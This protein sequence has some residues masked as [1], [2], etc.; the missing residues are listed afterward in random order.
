MAITNERIFGLAVPLSLADI[1]DRKDALLNI[2]LDDRDI[3]IIEGC[4]TA[5]FDTLDL[6]TL[7]GLDLP[8]WQTFDRYIADTLTYNSQLQAA[9]GVDFR[10]RGSLEVLG[11]LS[12]TAFRYSLLDTATSTPVL[13]WGDISTSRVSSWS[14]IDDTILYGADVKITGKL[15]VGS[16]KTRVIPNTRQF[17]AEVPTHKI[18]LRL[19]G[20]DQFLLVMKGIP[21]R[22]RG[23]FRD[24]SSTVNFNNSG[25]KASWRVYNSDGTGSIQDFPDIGNNSSSTLNYASPFSSEKFI[26]IYKNPVDITSLTLQNCSIQELPKSVLPNLSVFNFQN[27][28]L[29]EFP[30]LKKLIPTCS[31]L[32]IQNNPFFNGPD[33][34]ERYFSNK[35]ANK[36]PTTIQDLRIS[37]CF[38]G[39]FEQNTLRKFNALTNLSASRSSFN[40]AYFFANSFNPGGEVPCFYGV[41]GETS[42]IQTIDFNDNDF[43]TIVDGGQ[44]RVEPDT[45]TFFGGNNYTDGL[46]VDVPL[47][48]ISSATGS[49]TLEGTFVVNNGVVAEVTLTKNGTGYQV[50]DTLG[51]GTLGGTGSGFVLTVQDIFNVQSVEELTSLTSLNLNSNNNLFKEKF[52]VNSPNTLTSLSIGSTQ[53]EMPNVASYTSLNS[54][55]N[56]YGSNRGSFHVG[57]GGI[58]GRASVT[59]VELVDGGTGGYSSGIVAITDGDGTGLELNVT[60]FGGVVTDIS[61]ANAGK[62]Y[63]RD[64]TG[65]LTIPGGTGA[66]FNITKVAYPVDD[67]DS[68]KFANCSSL[69]SHNVYASDVRGYLPKYVGCTALASYSFEAT[70]SIVA[71][72]PG[73][74][75]IET[76]FNSGGIVTLGAYTVEDTSDGNSIVNGNPGYSQGI[77]TVQDTTNFAAS[78]ISPAV[79]EVNIASNGRPDNTNPYT[80]INP[81][82]GYTSSDRI[83]IEATEFNPPAAKNESNNLYI[84]ITEVTTGA[85]DVDGQSGNFDPSGSPYLLEDTGRGSFA[86]S[87]ASVSVTV[88]GAG[89]IDGYGLGSSGQDYQDD[90]FISVDVPL[91]GGGTGEVRVQISKAE[92]PKILYN[93]QFSATPNISTLDIRINNSLF[94]GEIEPGALSSI[95]GTL[96]I[97]RLTAAGRITGDFPFVEDNTKLYEV[98]SPNQGWTGNIPQFSAATGLYTVNL[99][100]NKFTGQLSYPNKPSLN[101]LN[102]NSNQLESF[103]PTLSLPSLQY[104]YASNNF[105]GKNLETGLDDPTTN[106]LPNL[107]TICPNVQFVNLSNNRFK[108]Y[109]KGFFTDLSVL[110]S[111]DLSSNAL[112]QLQID[113]ILFDFVDNYNNS[114]RSGVLVNLQGADMSPPT[115]YPTIFNTLVSIDDP[116]SPT[117]G[118]GGIVDGDLTTLGGREAGSVLAPISLSK[119]PIAKKYNNVATTSPNGTGATVNVDITYNT[120]KDIVTS[121]TTTA[122]ALSVAGVIET[123][124]GTFAWSLGSNSIELQDGTFTLTADQTLVP[125]SSTNGSGAQVEVTIAPDGIIDDLP[126]LL[127]NSGNTYNAGDIVTGVAASGSGVSVRI[128]GASSGAI[129]SFTI[130]DGGS[131]YIQGQTL[132]LDDGT[133]DP[134][135]TSPAS[136]SSTMDVLR[137]FNSITFSLVTGGTGYTLQDNTDVIVLDFNDIPGMPN[138][139]NNYVLVDIST[140]QEYQNGTYTLTTSTD[141]GGTGAEIEVTVTDG[142]VTGSSIAGTIVSIPDN[143]GYAEDDTLDVSL[144]GLGASTTLNAR[145]FVATVQPYYYQDGDITYTATIN[146]VGENYQPGDVLTTVPFAEFRD[147]T[148]ESANP[149]LTLEQLELIVSDAPTAV[150]N[151]INKKVFTGQGAVDFL[152]SKGWT[153]QVQ[154]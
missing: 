3:R 18:K 61:V 8:I 84:D 121:C 50:G 123:I 91:Q 97:L 34:E 132:T 70:N 152:R 109:S 86:G 131:G 147:E 124:P 47:T 69:T 82:I 43:K 96:R 118:N 67:S 16:L 37:G 98:Y 30:D 51:I 143:G 95:A 23:F 59:D 21:I 10:T 7:S 150:T 13:R 83:E 29:I 17:K 145:F 113:T 129:T 127:T 104:F 149:L 73:K 102:V 65:T 111:I 151:V 139:S 46:Y 80:I 137:N 89:N 44:G 45:F 119:V 134:S 79:L 38:K 57:W 35:V 148:D 4:S 74:R 64:L 48:N 49:N 14:S 128:D 6:Q 62:N 107:D 92:P 114:P 41:D 103:S 146:T 130:L 36:I 75:K 31:S 138:L 39:A 9:A 42:V 110:R 71:G 77:Y 144:P 101:Y 19:N 108:N 88:N 140:I 141:G 133:F 106:S 58:F 68:F 116:I 85:I 72:R 28:G 153:I 112:A 32:F 126:G 87:G 135:P 154:A 66:T 53:L 55:S 78:V 52:R 2:G 76:L 15:S 94:A 136:A 115:P 99:S 5:G 22:F 93:D 90:E 26:E 60:A 120:I 117:V 11:G 27:N 142:G 25:V 122:T 56:V 105:F 125:S 12:S 54:V 63:K 33:P 24:F 40:G 100:G 1:P 20:V 81:G